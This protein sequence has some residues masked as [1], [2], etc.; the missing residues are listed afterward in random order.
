VSDRWG[1]PSR[2]LPVGE[3]PGIE[4]R[5]RLA[6][7]VR[8][9]GHG[10]SGD[11]SIQALPPRRTLMMRSE[12]RDAGPAADGSPRPAVEAFLKDDSVARAQS[13]V[14]AITPPVVFARGGGSGRRSLCASRRHVAGGE[15]IAVAPGECRHP[16]RKRRFAA[17]VA[18]FVGGLVSER[19]AMRAVSVLGS[20]AG[21]G[22]G[23]VRRRSPIERRAL[24]LRAAATRWSR[25]AGGPTPRVFVSFS[26]SVARALVSSCW[27]R[28]CAA[29]LSA[30]SAAGSRRAV[31]A[32]WGAV[33]AVPK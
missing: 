9:T 12:R 20:V 23:R 19:R 33:G 18:V 31:N 13:L 3:R 8:R 27:V 11:L 15:R 10:Q 30:A 25:A 1:V 24:A 4:G 2:G 7:R 16:P 5:G 17:C 26:S 6:G 28:L 32:L 22:C 21:A 14:R 29:R